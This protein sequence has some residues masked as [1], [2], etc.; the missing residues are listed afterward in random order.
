MVGADVS[1]IP[2]YSALFTKKITESIRSEK[3]TDFIITDDF[4]QG[5]LIMFDLFNAAAPSARNSEG[6]FFDPF[7]FFG[8]LFS[9]ENGGRK[10]F[11]MPEIPENVMK[12]LLKYGNRL[13]GIPAGRKKMDHDFE[14]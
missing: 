14:E 10:L 3:L 5:N 2:A 4:A 6:S 7:G 1:I 13:A 12:A 11:R 8:S 9:E